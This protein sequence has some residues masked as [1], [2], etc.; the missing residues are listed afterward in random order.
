M[1]GFRYFVMERARSLGLTGWVRNG[2]DGATV[3]VAA[4][5]PDDA[6]R[7]LESALHRGPGAARVEAVDA[8]WTET[9]EGYSGF[10]LRH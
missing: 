6:L 9:P 10:A 5:G 2:A 8:D 3:E 7:D 1:V 4:E